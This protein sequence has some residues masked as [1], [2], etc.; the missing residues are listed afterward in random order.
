M[1]RTALHFFFLVV[2]A[3]STSLLAAED[4]FQ[5]IFNGKDLSGW[6]SRAGAWKVDD[7][8]IT[9]TGIK[10]SKNWI[11]WRGGVLE[12]FEL[13]LK[14]RWESGNS[15]IQVRSL[16]LGDHQ[17]R[18]SQFEVAKQE[19]MGLWHHSLWTSQHRRFLATA[20]Q[21]VRI[22][23]DGTK[24]V[25]IFAKPEDVQ[26]AYH[27]GE[28]NDLV[29]RGEGP[30]LTQIING[31]LFSDVTDEERAYSRRT[32]LLA[33]QDHGKGTVAAFKDIRIKHLNPKPEPVA[34]PNVLFIAVDDLNTDLGC[35]GNPMV[36]S[37][38]IDRLADRG[39]RFELAYCQYPVC[40]PSR[41][42]FMTS[43]YPRQTGI[44]SNKGHIRDNNPEVVTLAQNFMNHGYFSGRI[45]KIFHYGVPDQIGTPGDD[46]AAS[47]QETVNPIGIDKEVEDRI[48]SLVPGKFGGTLSWLAVDSKDGEHTDGKG[49]TGCIEML[50]THH[51]DK[52]GKPFFIAM[53]FYRP[54]TPYVAP[55]HYI[56]MYSREKIDPVMEVPGDRDDIP[57][58]AL[59]DR[60]HQRELSVD[61][62][63]EIIQAYY[64]STTLMD[65][66]VGRLLEALDRLDLRKNTIIVFISDHGYHLGRHGLWQKS[67][68][69]EGSAHVPMIIVDPRTE[70]RGVTSRA[71]VELADLYPTL[72]DLCGLPYPK[73]VKGKSLVPVLNDPTANVREGSYTLTVSRGSRNGTGLPKS[74]IIGD[75]IRTDRYRYTE[76]GEGEYGHELYDYQ[77]D[78]IEFHNLADDPKHADTLK[79]L[80]ALLEKHREYGR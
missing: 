55:T 49:A 80:K 4:G 18:G 65:A 45:G 40:N 70:A 29:I 69:F 44:L 6:D 30:R 31:V 50:E 24:S 53:G 68:L 79:R 46:D 21:R 78:P 48:H 35:Y 13:R 7:G 5:T 20:G 54:H 14:F 9:A 12:D 11:I 63:K 56:E 1:K 77:A 73:H 66:Q 42:S 62:R 64:A 52:T 60:P 75:S 8:A 16:D 72:S 39:T 59:H 28:W 37:P 33:F 27:E 19:D 47:W 38:N 15:G 26:K 34:K 76:W 71:R 2:L 43:L 51:P 22:A 17:V 57:A 25:E 3:T 23:N 10:G 32:G 67:D 74:Q 41:S 58:A 61:Q 36:M